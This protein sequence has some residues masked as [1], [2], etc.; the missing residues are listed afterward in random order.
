MKVH[1]N[2][3]ASFIPIEASDF[4]ALQEQKRKRNEHWLRMRNLIKI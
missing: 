1:P 4:E 3:E 2:L